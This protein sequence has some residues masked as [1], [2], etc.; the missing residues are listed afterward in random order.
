MACDTCGSKEDH[1]ICILGVE[2]LDMYYDPAGIDD[3]AEPPIDEY[4]ERRL[5]LS[6]AG[7][8][9]NQRKLDDYVISSL[10]S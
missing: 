2:R 3:M 7:N 5:R 9:S 4:A 1:D 6:S 8:R 10:P